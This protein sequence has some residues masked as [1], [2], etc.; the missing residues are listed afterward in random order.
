M[1]NNWIVEEGEVAA[2]QGGSSDNS[3][4]DNFKDIPPR[5]TNDGNLIVDV[6]KPHSKWNRKNVPAEYFIPLE[7]VINDMYFTPKTAT[8]GHFPDY[9]ETGFSNLPYEHDELWT[10]EKTGDGAPFASQYSAYTHSSRVSPDVQ[11]LL[12][13]PINS[14]NGGKICFA[15]FAEVAMPWE[16]FRFLLASDDFYRFDYGTT[17]TPGSWVDYCFEIPPGKKTLVWSLTE[18]GYFEKSFRE[19]KV[20]RMIEKSREHGTNPSGH[21]LLDNVRFYPFVYDNFETG[22]FSLQKWRQS[23][24]GAPWVVSEG[25]AFEGRYAAHVS[26]SRVVACQTHVAL[27][28]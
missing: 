21:V 26:P 28:E 14:V 22:D 18:P 12:K 8:P 13:L 15:L 19:S 24:D 17:R 1:D 5:H 9:F 27:S 20:K 6:I 2:S 11:A 16:A 3:A 23:G 25:T 10:I 7:D 4:D